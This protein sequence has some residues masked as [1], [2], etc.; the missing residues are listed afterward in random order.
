MAA[1]DEH[2]LIRGYG[3][4]GA[5]AHDSEPYLD[6]MPVEPTFDGQKA[7]GD[8]AYSGE[9]IDTELKGRGYDPQICEK[10]YTP[11]N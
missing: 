6:V 1:D 5:A 9:K 11:T 3:V 8:S 2:K 10:G 4:T 7:Y